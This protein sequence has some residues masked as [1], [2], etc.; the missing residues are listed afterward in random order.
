MNFNTFVETRQ[1]LKNMRDII[2]KGTEEAKS[3]YDSLAKIM[4]DVCPHGTVALFPVN[5]FEN[6]PNVIQVCLNMKDKIL[7]YCVV[8][9]PKSDDDLSK[10]KAEFD[11][12]QVMDDMSSLSVLLKYNQMK[13]LYRRVTDTYTN[14]PQIK[15]YDY[16][17]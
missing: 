9:N 11:N 17:M 8:T 16:D 14:V 7:E 15:L 10:L 6:I 12:I 13:N 4:N 5:D 3:Y 1:K 2:V